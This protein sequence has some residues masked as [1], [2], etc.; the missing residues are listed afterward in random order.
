M[1]RFSFTFDRARYR[2]ARGAAPAVSFV[3]SY[4][5]A[6]LP[7]FLQLCLRFVRYLRARDAN[8]YF[9]N[10]VPRDTPNYY[11]V[12]KH[13]ICIAEI[14]DRVYARAY[15]SIA[16]FKRDVDLIW[17]NCIAY[18]SA[19]DDLSKI[20]LRMKAEFDEA[21]ALHAEMRDV[22]AAGDAWAKMEEAVGVGAEMGRFGA[23]APS[24]PPLPRHAAPKP[25][26]SKVPELSAAQ[27]ND[28]MTE[29]EKYELAKDI[30]V[31]PPE[32]LGGI[33]DI[34]RDDGKYDPNEEKEDVISFEDLSNSTL[35]KIQMYL[36]NIKETN[37]EI[38]VRKMYQFDPGF[39]EGVINEMKELSDKLANRSKIIHSAT[40][41]EGDTSN[42]E[43]DSSESSNESDSSE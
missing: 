30:N 11:S 43:S 9:T 37:K 27:S 32:L 17:A 3:S 7:D 18:N 42:S 13:P 12:I 23:G 33:V 36:M 29:K 39:I 4:D 5:S 34:L 19:N 31:L 20:A 22:A 16:E 24:H 2:R 25:A 1:T 28:M 41:S 8:R 40:T 21:F 38:N 6:A 35:R 10:S 26:G 14:E 15:G